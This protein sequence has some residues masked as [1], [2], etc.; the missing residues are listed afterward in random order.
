MTDNSCDKPN[1]ED[2]VLEQ[3]PSV[4]TRLKQGQSGNPRGGRRKA[5]TAADLLAKELHST[6]FVTANGHRIKTNK[7]GLLLKQVVDRAIAGNFQPLALVIG[8]CDKL[9]QLNSVPTKK[10]AHPYDGIDIRKLSFDEK[11]KLLDEI[12]ANSKSI[13]EIYRI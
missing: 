1:R 8:I 6:V 3:R 9:E 5:V 2:E 11:Q 13:E 10:V 4:Q 7:L 12:L